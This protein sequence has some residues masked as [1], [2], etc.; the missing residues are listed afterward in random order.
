MRAVQRLRPFLA[1]FALLTTGAGTVLLAGCG[2]DGGTPITPPP[3]QS[4]GGGGTGGG[5]G[6]GGGSTVDPAKISAAYLCDNK[7]KLVN[8]NA[9]AVAV[10]YTIGTATNQTTVD[11]PA[12]P[13]GDPGVSE[14]LVNAGA[15]GTLNL[16]YIGKKVGTAA[17]NGT[18]CEPPPPPPPPPPPANSAGTVGSWAPPIAWPDVA[19]HMHL[20]PDGR[21]LTWGRTSIPPQIWNPADG[22]FS[23]ATEPANLFC[24][25]HDWLPD[26]TLFI[27]GGH[28]GVDGHGITATTLFSAATQSFAAASPMAHA[29][30][31]PSATVLPNGVV[32]VLTGTDEND[33]YVGTPEIWSNGSWR[34]A[35]AGESYKILPYYPRAFAAPNGQLFYA[36]EKQQT[37]YYDPAGLGKWTAVADRQVASRDYGS[38]VMYQPGKIIYIGGGAPTATAEMIDLNQGSPSWRYTSPMSTPRRQMNATLLADGKVLAT[39]GTAA[40]GFSDVTGA[41]FAAEEWDPATE[42]WTTMASEQRVRV[43]HSTAVLLPDGRVLEAG[44]GAGGGVPDEL[45]GEIFSPPYLFTADGSPAPRPTITSL[46]SN[47]T[48]GQAVTVG[49]PDAASISKVTFLRLGSVTHAFNAGQR[50]LSLS[51]SQGAGG[52]QV[53]LP[54]SVGAAPAGPYMMFILNGAGVPSVAKI[55]ILQ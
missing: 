47:G 1:G 53:T 11:L 24:S 14:T 30:W 15:S 39:G 35:T 5:T 13:G 49:T 4:G 25:G 3:S 43:Y 19:I 27:A 16:Y 41:V 7:F 36:G 26:G 20:L 48:W 33:L 23:T 10:Q 9:V 34:T 51:F 31:Y 18:P 45:S 44:S 12:G 2:G 29:R 32:V 22:S 6:G 38:A 54:S 55:M 52:L 37:A 21:V 42:Q 28:S 50:F 17:N 8:G 40:P 46:P